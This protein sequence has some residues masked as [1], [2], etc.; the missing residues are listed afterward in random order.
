M[1]EENVKLAAFHERI[2]D[3]LNFRS[4]GH[5]CREREGKIIGE[6]VKLAAFHERIFFI[7]LIFVLLVTRNVEEKERH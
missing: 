1:T 2:V 3:S 7:L 6:N 5:N 4:F